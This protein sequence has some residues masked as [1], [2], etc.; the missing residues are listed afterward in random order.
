MLLIRVSCLQEHYFFYF[1]LFFFQQ[2]TDLFEA[3]FMTGC[4]I[5]VV[6]WPFLIIRDVVYINPH[7]LDIVLA[8]ASYVVKCRYM[9][10]G[11]HVL[12]ERGSNWFLF[13]F[14]L[15]FLGSLLLEERLWTYTAFLWRSHL[16]VALKRYSYQLSAMWIVSFTCKFSVLYHVQDFGIII[17]LQLAVTIFSDRFTAS[18]PVCFRWSIVSM[19]V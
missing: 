1:F 7:S 14:T 9:E 19:L 4:F 16:E 8:F 17:V 13:I 5:S 2:Y 10:K 11:E 18:F 6:L 3:H 15:C 12:V